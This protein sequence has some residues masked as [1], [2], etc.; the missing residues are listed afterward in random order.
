VHKILVVDDEKNIRMALKQCLLAADYDVDVA[1]NGLEGYNMI[2]E[3]AFEV[4]L[5]DIK[6]PGLSG[7]EVLK[8]IRKEGSDISVIMMTAYGTIESAVEAMK[9]GAIDFLSKPF[10][11][12]EIRNIVEDV[13]E[14]KK[15]D[16]EKVES[17]KEIMQ[18][19]KKSILSKDFELAKSLLSRAISINMDSPEPHN[20]LGTIFEY[21]SKISLAQ[22]HYR[23]ALALDPTYKPAEANLERT[24][25]FIYHR[26]GINLGDE[27]DE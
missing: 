4:V 5:L 17:Y 14:R 24:A 16:T 12:E 15:I 2:M 7:M 18:Y 21:N 20:L 26:E 25:Q 9:L 3:G 27:E 22:K 10:V 23:A 13:I 11:P 6:M 1:V 19:A 8:K